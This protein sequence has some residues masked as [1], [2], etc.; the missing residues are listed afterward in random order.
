MQHQGDLDQP[1]H[2]RD[3]DQADQDEVDDRGPV[4]SP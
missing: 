4:L 1:E 3:E 2:E